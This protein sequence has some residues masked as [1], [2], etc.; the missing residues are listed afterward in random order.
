MKF[1][2]DQGD[3]VSLC[4]PREVIEFRE[5]RATGKDFDD[6]R[7]MSPNVAAKMT[8]IHK[9]H[10]FQLESY[11][12]YLLQKVDFD[13]LFTYNFRDGYRFEFGDSVFP[14]WIKKT[15]TKKK[16][17]AYTAMVLEA[18]GWIVTFGEDDTW[19]YLD[20]A[21]L[22]SLTPEEVTRE[23]EQKAKTIA[24][25][26]LQT[27]NSGL[28]TN[29]YDFSLAELDMTDERDLPFLLLCLKQLKALIPRYKIELF[30]GTIYLTPTTSP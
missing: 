27:I 23:R 16:I 30:C 11:I 5:N 9:V 22:L 17:V 26:A 15:E 2:P 21:P 18:Y 20:F 14:E 24:A 13:L 12:C 8:T 7:P 10:G 4:T 28:L 25:K 6:R 29:K 1:S 3:D 19:Y